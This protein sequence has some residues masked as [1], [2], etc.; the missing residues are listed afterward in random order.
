MRPVHPFQK[1]KSEAK[2][3]AI[4]KQKVIAV[5]FDGVIH[6]HKNPIAGKRMGLPIEGTKEALTLLKAKDYQIIIFSVWGYEK[7]SQAISDY[8]KFYELP[9]DSITNIKPKAEF[10]IDDK[11]IKFTNW[12]E[13]L[14]QI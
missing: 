12:D 4:Q 13:V 5:D 6:N 10:Y 9:F 7:G 2:R 1:S 14:K 3:L 8:M 11:G